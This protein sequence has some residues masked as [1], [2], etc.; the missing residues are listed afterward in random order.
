[1]KNIIL[2]IVLLVG[3]S[4]V[5]FS[6]WTTQLSGSNNYI[7]SIYFVDK[8]YGVAAAINASIYVTFNA[9][10]NWTKK[11][12]NISGSINN[13]FCIDK[14]TAWILGS[15]SSDTNQCKIT[16][17]GFKTATTKLTLPDGFFLPAFNKVYYYNNKVWVICSYGRTYNSI[18]GENWTQKVW[19]KDYD[20]VYLIFYDND[21]GFLVAN[22]QGIVIFSTT[23]G[24][25]TWIEQKSN[26]TK[27]IY[28]CFFIDQFYGWA[29]NNQG[30]V[31]NTKDGG[32]T[33]TEQGITKKRLHGV[34]FINRNE[35]W[36]VG[37]SG[38]IFSTVDGGETWI[39]E[40]G[41][42]T[43]DLHCIFSNKFNDWT[44]DIYAGG[45]STNI[46]NQRY[47]VSTDVEENPTTNISG[48]NIYPNPAND[49]IVI[50][51]P[52]ID[53]PSCSLIITNSLGVELKRLSGSE[54][55]NKS[56]ILETESFTSGLYHCSIINNNQ[57]SSKPF[58]IIR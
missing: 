50:H 42:T 30:F 24:G 14:T 41:Y 27:S 31:F 18:D 11:T 35:G 15:Q 9:G 46:I 48:L 28:S 1:M 20:F 47:T 12:S 54:L 13:I 51:L 4:N 34:T 6:Q 44:Y 5:V 3:F 58:I 39:D 2:F 57:V 55:L 23:D 40:S 8:D 43:A 33:W 32:A 22:F 56:I 7:E 29:V 19:D 25:N 53:L 36:I 17:D 52:D 21:N 10:K 49:K 37:A 16:K 38:T 45:G 26:V